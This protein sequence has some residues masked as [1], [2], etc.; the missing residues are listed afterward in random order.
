MYSPSHSLVS[1]VLITAK[2]LPAAAT[3]F[4]KVLL[5]ASALFQAATHHNISHFGAPTCHEFHLLKDLNVSEFRHVS[6]PL[7]EYLPWD[8]SYW[9]V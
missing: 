5:S 1:V 4:L 9:Q 6:N 3:Q 8:H 2:H 7:L